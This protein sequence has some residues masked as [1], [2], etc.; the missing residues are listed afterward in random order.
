MISF[1]IISVQN[2]SE[3]Q[4]MI[5]IEMFK[6]RTREPLRMFLRLLEIYK[7]TR[8]G[9]AFQQI[10]KCSGTAQL[11]TWMNS[12]AHYESTVCYLHRHFFKHEVSILSLPCRPNNT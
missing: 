7:P 4:V 5:D 1:P 10:K 9:P 3:K 2:K 12:S 6:L 8:D 11:L